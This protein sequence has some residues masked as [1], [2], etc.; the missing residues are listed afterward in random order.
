MNE[1]ILLYIVFFGM[2]LSMLWEI[3]A[4]LE[5]IVL[6]ITAVPAAA[7]LAYI[8]LCYVIKERERNY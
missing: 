5:S 6:V 4:I 1:K 2:I 8:T 3:A 7:G